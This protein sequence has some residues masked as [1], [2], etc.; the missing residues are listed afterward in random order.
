[1]NL[2]QNTH[3]ALDMTRRLRAEL[4]ND[5]LAMCHGLLE[6]RA[7]AMAVFEASHLA[8]SADTREAVTPLIRELHQEDQKLRQR[9][10][11]MMQ[12]T[13]QRLREGLRSA[14]GPGQQ[15]YNT[16]SPPSCVDR[17]A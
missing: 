15:A 17:R 14:S 3:A 8:A 11:E 10:T 9:L 4:E 12:E 6:R 5:D 1:M 7:E 2:E 13:G 16:T